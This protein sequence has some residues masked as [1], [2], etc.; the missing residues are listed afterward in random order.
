MRHASL[1]RS[2]SFSAAT[3]GSTL[4]SRNSSDAPP[5]VET[6]VIF[7]ATPAFFTA[8]ALSPPPMTVVAPLSASSLAMAKVPSANFGNSNTP[9]GPF[10]TTSLAASSTSPNAA[11]LF[12][13]MSRMRQPAGTLSTSTTWLFASASNLSATTASTGSI[14]LPPALARMALAV[15]TEPASTRLSAMS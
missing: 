13:P 14:S 4:P 3:P 15:S 6:C 12:G 1:I 9:I 11:M 5:P 7:L 2:L 10:Q 8:L